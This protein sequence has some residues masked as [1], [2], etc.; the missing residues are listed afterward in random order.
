MLSEDE[1]QANLRESDS[2]GDFRFQARHRGVER[3]QEFVAR[4]DFEKVKSLRFI[5]MPQSDLSWIRDCSNVTSISINSN[6]SQPIDVS[7]LHNLIHL[8]A[9]GSVMK[10]IFGLENLKP[11]KSLS[12][13]SPTEY[14]LAR[15][16][17]NAKL[18]FVG[19]APK[20]W[21]K[22]AT[23]DVITNLKIV[24]AKSEPLDVGQMKHL[25]NLEFLSLNSI[26]SG[27]CN[28]NELE[29]LSNLEQLFL[30]KVYTIDSK[31]WILKL[32]KLRSF[33]IWDKHAFDEAELDRLRAKGLYKF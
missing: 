2:E 9:Q 15:L 14:E 28:A 3:L 1:I 5:E 4:A 10:R 18:L 24:R 11:L 31:D 22:L 23:P 32:P 8:G 12:F 16:G 33:T 27:L 13:S 21:P 26:Y 30:W 25:S 29:N 7:K 20:A 19:G 17:G 6:S